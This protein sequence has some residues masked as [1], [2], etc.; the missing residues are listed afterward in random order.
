[1]SARRGELRIAD[2]AY[3]PLL[4]CIDNPPAL[5]N[6]EGSLSVLRLPMV[7][8][9][10]SR[11]A[12]DYGR[13][14]AYNL[15]RR[16]SGHGVCVV[17]G[18][19]EG[20]DSFAHRGALEGPTPT[21]AV[22]GN[23]LDIC[24]PKMN[25]ALREHI[26]AAGLLLSEYANGVHGTRYTFPARNRIISGLCRATVVVEAG[27]SSGSLITAE[28]AAQQGRTVYAVPGNINRKLSV[29][30]NKL[31]RDG[32]RPLVFFDDI[33]DD[34]GLRA[35]IAVKAARPAG[36]AAGPAGVAGTQM[37]GAAEQVLGPDEALVL[38][39]VLERGEMTLDDAAILTKLGV[40]ACTGIV[41]LLEMKG[42]VHFDHGFII[43][44]NR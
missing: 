36:V 21:A 12:T 33:L 26:A 31:I 40:P 2:E 9:V 3:P 38:G 6:Y 22:M 39:A 27:L 11:R 8:I 7:A 20:I 43:P 41:T 25:G 23:G 15:A 5:L 17:S 14:A 30:C 44:A 35:R 34:L 19:A 1:M 29:G 4:R 32:A 37:P 42:F 10:G 18:M 24:F 16:L 13:W 28:H